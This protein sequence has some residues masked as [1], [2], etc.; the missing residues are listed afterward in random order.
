MTGP[1]IASSSRSLP[2]EDWFTASSREAAM[3][4]PIA[5]I[6]EAMHEHGDADARRR[7]MPARRAAS[8][9]PPTAKTWRPKRVRVVMYWNTT[10]NADA[11][12]ATASGTPRSALSTATVAMIAAATTTSG[13]TSRA[14]RRR[15]QPGR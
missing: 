7:V 14:H 6:V 13:R 10:T 3:M 5:A 2:P 4:P 11:G 8:A 12:S 1:A 15:R 9:L